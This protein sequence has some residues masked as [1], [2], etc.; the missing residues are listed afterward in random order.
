MFSIRFDMRA[1]RFGAATTDLYAA[2][3]DMSAWAEQHGC[4]AAVLCEHHGSEDGYLPAPLM[5]AS[6]IAARTERLALSVVVILPFYDP[7]RLAEDVAVLDILSNGRA[8]YVFGLGYRPE[9]FEHFGIDRSRRGALADENLDLLR[10]LLTGRPTV[11][12]NRRIMVSPP[13]CTRGGPTL[14]WGGA[15]L[16][17]AR[18]AGRYG[19]G[20]LANGSVTGMR[21]AYETASRAHGHEPGG[22]LLPP[23]DTPT[24]TFVAD[25]VDEG[26]DEI[27]EH[28]FHDAR[29]YAQWNPDNH[30]SAG[31][32]AARDVEE[33]RH[34]YTS[35]RIISSE[36]AREIIRGGGFLNLSPLCG[37]IPPEIAWPY[38]R[39]A[40]DA[41]ATPTMTRES[42][43]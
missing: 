19:L 34:H 1:P 43:R 15:S 26:W 10:T 2:A 21:D 42:S 38:L 16:A 27:G 18:R 36:Q 39:R 9:E 11:H 32:S 23:P 8:S 25:D 41:A 31:I 30:A 40:A 17:A 12:D 33:L 37:G 4:V 14:M 24:V 13:P 29:M 20:L 28:L 5:L 3:I 22:V 35:H 7:V 6:A